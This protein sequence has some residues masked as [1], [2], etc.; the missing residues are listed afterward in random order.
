MR[1]L[2][3]HLGLATHGFGNSRMGW[4]TCSGCSEEHAHSNAATNV[5]SL[6]VLQSAVG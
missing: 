6:C 5:E 4:M 1:E 2:M 3:L